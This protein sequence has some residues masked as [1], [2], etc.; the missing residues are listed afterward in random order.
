MTILYLPK[1]RDCS[2]WRLEE[3]GEAYLSIGS[4]EQNG[5]NEKTATVPEMETQGGRGELLFPKG[6]FKIA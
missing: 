6:F 2:A 5:Y 1:L 3:R 4:L